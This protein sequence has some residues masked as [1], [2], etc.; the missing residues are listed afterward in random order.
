MGQQTVNLSVQA[1]QKNPTNKPRT[2]I[3]LKDSPTKRDIGPTFQLQ[4]DQN[5][6]T[7]KSTLIS[8]LTFNVIILRNSYHPPTSL[9]HQTTANCWCILT[10]GI[11]DGGKIWKIMSP[12]LHNMAKFYLHVRNTSKIVKKTE[13]YTYGVTQNKIN[14]LEF[15]FLFSIFSLFFLHTS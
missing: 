12:S 2:N 1:K 15:T 14:F 6:Q 9:Y 11:G 10:S 5:Q 8:I 7:N 13:Q 4:T 3:Q